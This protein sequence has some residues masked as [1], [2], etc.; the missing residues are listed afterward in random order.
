MNKAKV[1]LLIGIPLLILFSIVGIGLARTNAAHKTTHLAASSHSTPDATQQISTHTGKSLTAQLAKQPTPTPIPKAT[2][3]PAPTI[4]VP[5]PTQSTQSPSQSTTSAGSAIRYFPVGTPVAT[6]QADATAMSKQQV[7]LLIEKEVNANLGVI[8]T[9]LGFSS[10]QQAYAFFL[11]MATRESTLNAGLETGSGPSHSYG[12]IQAA[13]PAYAGNPNYAQENDVPQ[14]MQFSFTPQNFYDPGIAVYMG[15]RHLLHFSNQ[16]RTAGY[17]GTDMLRHTLAG[18]N[19]G[20]VNVTDQNE[21]QSYSDEIGALTGWYLYNAHL[22]DT[23]FTW[24]GDP[25]VNRSQPWG[26]Y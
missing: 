23:L 26:W 25:R 13:E 24:T 18:Y 9:K 5:T 3:T 10:E 4:P 8:E 16:A 12:P 6:M 17:T 20:N 15:I 22:Y 7:K 2:A 21:L 11:G 14:M 19:T 1:G